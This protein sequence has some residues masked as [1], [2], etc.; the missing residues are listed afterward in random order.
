MS[1]SQ[2]ASVRYKSTPLAAPGSLGRPDP[3]IAVAMYSGGMDSAWAIEL[4]VEQGVQVHALSFHTMFCR[5]TSHDGGCS[6]A[7]DRIV[8]RLGV[9]PVRRTLKEEYV[10]IIKHP[11]FGHGAGVNP[12][13][14]CRALILR[15]GKEYMAEVG[16][17]FIITGEVLG[18]RPMSQR[19]DAMNLID[20]AVDLEGWILRPLCA[21]LMAPTWPERWGWIDRE[22]MLSVSGRSRSPQ[23]DWATS[24]EDTDS[25]VLCPSIGCLLTTK[26]FALRVQDLLAFDPDADWHAFRTLLWGRHFRLP[27]KSKLILTRD[28]SEEGALSFALTGWT[29]LEARDVFGAVGFLPPCAPESDIPL[30]ASVVAGYGKGAATEEVVVTVAAVGLTERTETVRPLSKG[31]AHRWL[32]SLNADVHDK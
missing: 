11:K 4:M 29:R 24:H 23:I 16:G 19:R 5:C 20:H 10:E 2:E 9:K 22:R 17:H 31:D 30:A 28:Q 8:D 27:G 25:K 7:M 13:L 3:L 26:E 1:E 15:K 6:A 12:C 32:V 18:Q 14:D 21:Q